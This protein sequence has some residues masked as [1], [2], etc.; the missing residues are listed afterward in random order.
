[1]FHCGFHR[2][3]VA[4]TRFQPMRD[5]VPKSETLLPAQPRIFHFRASL[6]GAFT[7]SFKMT[8]EFI[9]LTASATLLHMFVRPTSRKG[10][11][12]TVR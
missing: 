4:S 10:C 3:S 8:S 1:M 7:V 12:A 6:L 11:E 2:Y 5:G 9:G